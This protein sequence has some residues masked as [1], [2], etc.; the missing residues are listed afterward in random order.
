[1]ANGLPR[2][3]FGTE[4]RRRAPEDRYLRLFEAARD[5]ILLASGET[6]EVLDLNP[7][8][9]DLL[10][11]PRTD[12]IGRHFWD[13]EIFSGAE[14][15]EGTFRELQRN[16]FLSRNLAYSGRRGQRFAI[17]LVAHTYREAG[18]RVIQFSIRDVTG[19]RQLEEKARRIQEAATR[20]RK[21]EAIGRMAGAVAHD[22]NNLLT[23]IMGHSELLRL[24]LDAG[25]GVPEVEQ[26][27]RA[28]ESA[29]QLTRQLLSFGCRQ[30]SRP[31]VLHLNRAIGE[32]E[33]TIRMSLGS[34][35]DLELALA[36][37]LQPIRADPVQIEQVILNLVA[38]AR[39]AMPGGGRLKIETCYV[40]LDE[41]F[42]RDHPA[43]PAGEYICLVVSDNGVGMDEETKSHLFEPFFSTKPKG[44]GSGL[45]LPAVYGLVQQSKGY[46]SA[47]SEP[48]RGA[49]FRIYFPRPKE[50]I[51]R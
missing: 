51:N 35:I 3:V 38:N 33:Q 1:M 8:M 17:E 16:E 11:I 28:A 45:G 20:G 30:A 6:G 5:G 15:S 48:G 27:A 12:A 7:A 4:E 31:E 13:L 25:D 42:S 2:P 36:P 14:I 44:K 22:F 19:R 24:K 39:D 41:A 37:A 47:S 10:D 50:G 43:T 23:A 46:I 26:I 49:T 9:S 32:M 34:G 40:R 21:M 18:Q 29:A